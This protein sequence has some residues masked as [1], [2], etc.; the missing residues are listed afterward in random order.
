M[1]RLPLGF[2]NFGGIQTRVDISASKTPVCQHQ[3]NAL[4]CESIQSLITLDNNSAFLIHILVIHHDLLAN[5]IL[6]LV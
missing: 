5:C 2:G 3:Y 1:P 4:D 6:C